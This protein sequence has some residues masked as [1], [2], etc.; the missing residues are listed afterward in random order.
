[1]MEE[2]GPSDGPM[3]RDIRRQHRR[4]IGCHRD[5]RVSDGEEAEGGRGA[6]D[7]GKQQ[8]SAGVSAPSLP[9][10]RKKRGAGL[11]GLK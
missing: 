9:Q 11:E 2:S 5:R 1:M 4:G 3:K 10:V 6:S 7:G 8:R